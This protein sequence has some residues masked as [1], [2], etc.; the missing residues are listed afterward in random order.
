MN[1]SLRLFEQKVA[2]STNHCNIG[3]CLACKA[4][5]TCTSCAD[6]LVNKDG[7]CSG[8]SPRVDNCDA[9]NRE[10]CTSCLPG[11]MGYKTD[12]NY[13]NLKDCKDMSSKLTNCERALQIGGGSPKCSQCNPGF[14]LSSHKK[15]CYPVDSSKKIPNCLYYSDS[16]DICEGCDKGYSIHSKGVN[17]VC[18]PTSKD[19][20]LAFCKV[21]YNS[22]VCLSCDNEDN[23]WSIDYRQGVTG[24]MVCG[25]STSSF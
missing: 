12:K 3:K 9:S 5:Q 10:G 2:S 18:K 17:R 11:Y 24:T 16:P 21:I 13:Y 7:E 1:S 15:S 25:N 23:K 20:E 22:D 4:D 19:G 6:G 8:K 14:W